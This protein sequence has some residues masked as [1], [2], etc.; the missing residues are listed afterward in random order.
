MSDKL[1]LGLNYAGYCILG[2]LLYYCLTG[3][4]AI[5]IFTYIPDINTNSEI[6]ANI[7]FRNTYYSSYI[8]LGALIYYLIANVIGFTYVNMVTLRNERK[9]PIH[10]AR[11]SKESFFKIILISP[12]LFFMSSIVTL[13]S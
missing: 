8:P 12:I 13:R 1:P 10:D 5:C 6:F 9:N 11:S 3:L 4:L 2:S 7:Y